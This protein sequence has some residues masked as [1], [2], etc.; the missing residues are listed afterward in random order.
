M[1]ARQ[2]KA[3]V[4]YSTATESGF[5]SDGDLLESRVSF[6]LFEKGPTSIQRPKALPAAS[7]RT[8]RGAV[9]W[10]LTAPRCCI[11]IEVSASSSCGVCS[12]VSGARDGSVWLCQLVKESKANDY[13]LDTIDWMKWINVSLNW[14]KIVCWHHLPDFYYSITFLSKLHSVCRPEC[15]GYG[16]SRLE[17]AAEQCADNHQRPL[18]TH[19]SVKNKKKSG[20]TNISSTLYIHKRSVLFA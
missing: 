4:K 17:I 18:S 7:G 19:T 20:P 6:R 15:F 3:V 8:G 5:G 9:L 14:S 13:A 12:R 10:P 16:L 1:G 11:S 2:A